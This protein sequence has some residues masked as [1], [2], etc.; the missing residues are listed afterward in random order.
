MA[1]IH[2]VRPEPTSVSWGMRSK[3]ATSRPTRRRA[4]AVVS[5][6][7]PASDDDCVDVRAHHGTSTSTSSPSTRTA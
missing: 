5:P 1:L 2:S 4:I 3:T 7:M 6:P